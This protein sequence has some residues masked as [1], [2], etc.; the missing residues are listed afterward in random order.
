MPL[1]LAPLWVAVASL[2]IAFP[3]LCADESG[4]TVLK[5]EVRVGDSWTY[6]FVDYLTNRKVATIEDVVTFIG[7]DFLLVVSTDEANQRELDSHWTSEWGLVPGAQ[8]AY[9]PPLRFFNFPLK[10]GD[11]FETVYEVL[12][13]KGNSARYNVKATVKVTGWEEIEVPA[14]KF[15]ALRIESNGT[16]VRLD[17]VASARNRHVIWYVPEIE[18]WV[19]WTTE[20]DNPPE[21]TIN[22]Y[23]LVKFRLK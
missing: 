12:A 23:E 2:F 16:I 13:R 8:R 10:I 4:E 9:K 1:V 7:S 15:R 20:S 21:N 22:G 17:M 6:N 14:G 18:R 11:S 19:K 5:P 3:A